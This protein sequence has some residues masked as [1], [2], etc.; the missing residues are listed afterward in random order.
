MDRPVLGDQLADRDDAATGSPTV[1]TGPGFASVLRLLGGGLFEES[2]SDAAAHLMRTPFDRGE[3]EVLDLVVGTKDLAG[4][5][6]EDFIK[7]S[8]GD[9]VVGGGA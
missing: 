4:N 5:L 6:P 1:G 3:V 8:L 7:P 9:G 2:P